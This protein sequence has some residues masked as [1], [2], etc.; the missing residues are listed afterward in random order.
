MMKKDFM[1]CRTVLWWMVFSGIG[2][3]FMMRVQ[4]NLVIVAVVVPPHKTSIIGQCNGVIEDNNTWQNNSPIIPDDY[5]QYHENNS[6]KIQKSH[7]FPW[8]EYEQGLAT[9]AFYWIH[10]LSEIPGGMLARK[11]GTKSVFGIGNLL[12]ILLGFLLPVA[13]NYHLYAL[14]IIRVIQG[15]VGGLAYPAAHNMAAKWIP[16][17]ERSK[18]VSA[19]MGAGVGIGLAYPMCAFIINYI[20]WEA[21]F[22]IS[23][24]F[25]IVWYLAWYYLVFDTPMQHPRISEEERIYIE[26]NLET[27]MDYA[28]E[29]K[30]V[31]WR[32]IFT[33]VPFWMAIFANWSTVWG[34]YTLITEAPAYFAFVH[35]WNINEVGILSGLPHFFTMIFGWFFAQFSDWLLRTERMTVTNVRKLATFCCTGAPALMVLGL[36]FSGCHPILAI[37]FIMIGIASVGSSSSGPLVNLVDLSPNYASVLL[38]I[39]GLIV[40]CAG[41]LSPLFVG[42]MINNNQTIGQWQIIFVI[43]ALN[44]VVGFLLY[45]IW[46]TAKQQPWNNYEAVMT[47][48]NMEIR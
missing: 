37:I 15:F 41:F 18:F 23:S 9:G 2:I 25:G 44:M 42:L 11:Y 16:C 17:N 47:N 39:T 31:P 21:V 12:T 20:G 36:S 38:G 7:L 43:T 19:Y 10:M 6:Q 5:Q 30:S 34:Y 46:G 8:N 27:S 22:Y 24:I 13:M 29:N 48:D 33:S 45:Y 3:N 14:I 28:S 35:G 32:R 26:N 4:L 1:T 40:D